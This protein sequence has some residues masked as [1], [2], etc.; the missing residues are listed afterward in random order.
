[1]RISALI[2]ILLYAVLFLFLSTATAQVQVLEAWWIDEGETDSTGLGM[3]IAALG[4]VNGDGIEDLAAGAPGYEGGIPGFYGTGR[5]HTIL[6][7]T[8]YHQSVGI[9]SEIQSSIPSSQILLEAYPNPFN[10]TTVLSFQL[11][12]AG[13]IKLDIFDING[14]N[15]GAGLPR[16]YTDGFGEFDLHWY[17]PGTHQISFDGSGLTSGIYLVRLSNGK[18]QVTKKLVLIR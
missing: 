2:S 7:D 3:S 14:R 1:M 4:D 8:A 11:Q 10:A 16:P 17:P 18:N 9:P 13:F 12:V 6:G 5:V 15:V